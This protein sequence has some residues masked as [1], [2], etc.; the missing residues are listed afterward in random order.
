MFNI[1]TTGYH[2]SRSAERQLSNRQHQEINHRIFV[3]YILFFVSSTTSKK[4][5]WFS[6]KFTFKNWKK[7][8]K[9]HH[10]AYILSEHN[11]RIF[12]ND[13]KYL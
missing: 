11:E 10:S 7:K 13:V 1:H 2:I 5:K 4:Y 12:E 3:T 8:K 9:K 6:Y